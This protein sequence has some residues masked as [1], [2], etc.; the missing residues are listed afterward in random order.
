MTDTSFTNLAIYDGTDWLTPKH[1][2]LAGTKR[3]WLLQRG[4]IREADITLADLLKAPKVSLFNS[5]I[6]FGE[7]EIFSCNAHPVLH[8]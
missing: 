7:M 8:L 3:A 6:D 5:M 4:I 1:P 2:L